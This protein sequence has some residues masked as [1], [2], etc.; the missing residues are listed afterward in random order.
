MEDG[1]VLGGASQLFDGNTEF[2][3]NPEAEITKFDFE[4]NIVWQKQYGDSAYKY[5]LFKAIPA[6][7]G[8][9]IAVG[10]ISDG[11]A[12]GSDV[13]IIKT[14]EEGVLEWIN[15]WGSP[16]QWEMYVN[17]EPLGNNFYLIG[18]STDITPGNAIGYLKTLDLEGN[19]IG[20]FSSIIEGQ[21][22]QSL[23][24]F[25]ILQDLSVLMMIRI[26]DP[27]NIDEKLSFIV[28]L[29]SNFGLEWYSPISDEN[30]HDFAVGNTVITTNGVVYCGKTNDSG[31]QSIRQGFFG[32][33][34]NEG[35]QLWYR[36]YTYVNN[37]AS[38]FFGLDKI[39]DGF[40]AAGMTLFVPG[41]EPE[42][43][44]GELDLWLVRVDSMG[45]LVPGCHVGIEDLVAN[46]IGF[47]AY[48]N[49]C[50]SMI[51]LYF[52]DLSETYGSKIIITDSQ[53]RKVDEFN[54]SVFNSTY[55]YNVGKLAIG[56]YQFSLIKENQTAQT[57]RVVVQ[58]L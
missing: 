5:Q 9:I 20:A 29:N 18:G 47:K 57:I 26:T 1:Y 3:S 55:I 52:D 15:T 22:P 46:T 2:D 34:D 19:Q 21:E 44:L 28:K 50:S 11:T 32:K 45:C 4:G 23:E 33:V 6:I 8:G 17:I 42:S 12:G 31:S 35:S 41:D 13:L 7:D 48:P 39:E 27:D 49:P 43:E 10:Q 36:N 38:L 37:G 40:V 51:N 14:D 30:N 53:G 16:T 58:R 56:V 25:E 54:T 24:R